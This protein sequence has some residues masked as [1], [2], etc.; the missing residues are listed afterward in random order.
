MTSPEDTCSRLETEIQIFFA[1]KNLPKEKMYNCRVIII[2]PRAIIIVCTVILFKIRLTRVTNYY[3]YNYNL[4]VMM[5]KG[6]EREGI[7]L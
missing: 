6:E 1:E 5:M 2:I 7:C 3:S 4:R